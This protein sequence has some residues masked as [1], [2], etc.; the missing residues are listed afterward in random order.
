MGKKWEAFKNWFE[1]LGAY[2]D[3]GDVVLDKQE[4]ML[5]FENM[6]TEQKPFQSVKPWKSGCPCVVNYR[7]GNAKCPQYSETSA[8]SDKGCK[9]QVYNQ[10][11]FDAKELYDAAKAEQEQKIAERVAA[12]DEIFTR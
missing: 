6:F 2:M 10:K 5:C 11:Y 7:N 12:W 9:Y 3:Q 8:C 1:K 4:D